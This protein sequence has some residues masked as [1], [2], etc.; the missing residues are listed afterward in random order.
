MPGVQPGYMLL[1]EIG[2]RLRIPQ[3]SP[4]T[5]DVRG[6]APTAESEVGRSK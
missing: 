6:S 4:A 1:I 5:L 3:S 2:R